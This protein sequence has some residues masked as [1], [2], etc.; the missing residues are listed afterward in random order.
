MMTLN[1]VMSAGGVPDIFRTVAS[2]LLVVD[3]IEHRLTGS[4]EG[5]T[6]DIVY[7]IV[8]RVPCR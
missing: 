5:S 3:D 2:D 8:G 1:D 4:L 6:I 7:I